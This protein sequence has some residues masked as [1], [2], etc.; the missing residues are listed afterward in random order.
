MGPVGAA[1]CP[2]GLFNVMLGSVDNT[3]A[4]AMGDD[5]FVV[6]A[7]EEHHDVAF[8]GILTAPR[9]GYADVRLEEVEKTSETSEPR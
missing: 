4:N 7:R 9:K 2:Y 8:A 5:Y 3:L 6:K 1:N